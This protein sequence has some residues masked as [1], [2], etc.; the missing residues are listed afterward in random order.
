ML[1]QISYAV[2]FHVVSF[3][4]VQLHTMFVI[5]CLCDY[6]L[7][8]ISSRFANGRNGSTKVYVL[9]FS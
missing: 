2:V 3:A 4:N 7:D 1:L 9:G 8:V 6:C 5:V